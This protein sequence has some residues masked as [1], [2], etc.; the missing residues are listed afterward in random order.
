MARKSEPTKPMFP[1][2][3]EFYASLDKFVHEA[4]M[5]ADS[6]GQLL[7][8]PEVIKSESAR[9]ILQERLDAFRQARFGDE[10]P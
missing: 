5:L 2:K 6:V 8:M 1:I 7:R 4:G 9:K 10:E 3:H